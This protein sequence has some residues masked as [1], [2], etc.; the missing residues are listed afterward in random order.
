MQ[1]RIEQ[2]GEVVEIL[3]G[4]VGRADR[5][6]RPYVRAEMLRLPY[7]K[8]STGANLTTRVIYRA[9]RKPDSTVARK[10]VP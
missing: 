5:V 10:G 4:V 8:Y 6:V 7:V 1:M 3:C 9:L 2:T